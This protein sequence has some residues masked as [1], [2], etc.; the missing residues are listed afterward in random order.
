MNVAPQPSPQV[1]HRSASPATPPMLKEIETAQDF[2]S[3]MNGVCLDMMA[4][5]TFAPC[6][7]QPHRYGLVLR[8]EWTWRK[9]VYLTSFPLVSVCRLAAMAM[10][11]GEV[12]VKFH[13]ECRLFRVQNLSYGKCI[14]LTY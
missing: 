4:R 13:L 8:R 3:D 1:A 7:S 5:Y 11:L 10:E 6:F 14:E 9:C 12:E 2:H